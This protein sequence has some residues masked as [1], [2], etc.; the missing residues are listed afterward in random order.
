MYDFY[1]SI[2]TPLS[3]DGSTPLFIACQEG[4]IN[5]VKVLLEYGADINIVG[6]QVHFYCYNHDNNNTSLF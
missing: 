1:L 2:L 4:N 5:V 3:Q 6:Y